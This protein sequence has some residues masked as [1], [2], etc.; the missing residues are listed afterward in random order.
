MP[1]ST[2]NSNNPL[3]QIQNTWTQYGRVSYDVQV[4]V[5]WLYNPSVNPQTGPA[6]QGINIRWN[7]VGTTGKY[8][9]FGISFMYYYS[10]T[11][12]GDYIPCNI[13]P[14]VGNPC[15]SDNSLSN[16]LLLV[17]WQQTVVNGIEQKTWLAYA[18]LGNPANPMVS[19]ETQK[20]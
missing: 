1:L 15:G 13:K 12:C 9:G 2:T 10:R 8:Q 18:N 17:L 3:A 20:F 14:C 11:S 6:A 7:E 5:G 19:Q 4:K 16:R